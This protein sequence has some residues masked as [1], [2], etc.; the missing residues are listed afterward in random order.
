MSSSA[1]YLNPSD[2]ADRLGI[3][4]KALRLYEQRGL[5]TPVRTAAGWRTY[6][7]ADM[8]RAGE[9]AALRALGLSLAQVARVLKGDTQELAPALAAHQARLE[10]EARRIA[11]TV[12]KV[13]ILRAGLAGGEPPR[14]QELARLARPACEVVATFELPW[15]WGGE[16]FELR[17]VRAINYIIG[18]L[19]SGK[20]RFA[21]AI[22]EHLPGAIFV[23]LDRAANDAAD[24]RARMEADPVLKQRVE[25]ALAWLVEEGATA[26]PALRALLVAIEADDTQMPVID[27]IEQGLDQASQE[28]IASYLRNRGSGAR[29]LF[30]MTRS[31]AILDL[32]AVGR[33]EAIILCPAN[34]SPPSRVAPI[35]GAPGYEAVATCLAAPEVRARTEGVIAWRPQVA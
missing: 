20:T 17:D 7:P 12:G 6:G 32:G 23:D 4:Q 24:A 1:H 25:Q 19:G 3:S 16:R 14:M 13:R 29:P 8:A 22:A 34:H 28:A 5:I 9:I 21:K 15:P 26:T 33:D 10:T 18:P 31:T 11:E 27:M 2:A 30:I 35:P